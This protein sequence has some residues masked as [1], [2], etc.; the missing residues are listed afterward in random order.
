MLEI[1]S[2]EK[3]IIEN[4]QNR[5]LIR[6]AEKGIFVD[7]RDDFDRYTAIRHYHGDQHLNQAFDP[8]QIKFNRDDFWLLAQ[9]SRGEAIATYCLRRVMVE[10]FFE[11]IRSLALWTS[12]PLHRPN[13]RFVVACE[14]PTFGG[15]VVH[16][17]GLWVRDDYRGFAR[18]AVVLPH[19]ARA[20]ALRQRPFDHDS[21]MIRNNPGDRA[22]MAQRKAVFMGRKVYGFARVHRFVDGWFPPEG[23]EA[24]MHLCHSTRAEA[25]A[26]LASA[27][28][29]G[30]RLRRAGEFG[31]MPLVNQ[32]YEPVHT[33]TVLS[34]WQ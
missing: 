1:A 29:G 22:E 2:N 15:E 21:A 30:E 33:T 4:A 31:N 8:Q 17:G 3:R 23:R 10:D 28:P 25:V 26:S 6:L 18:L 14:I 7:Q 12:K 16:G 19:L 20:L 9:N 27:R 5:L 34:Q 24:I 13:S 32:N 11:L